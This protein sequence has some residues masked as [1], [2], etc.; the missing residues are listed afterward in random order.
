MELHRRCRST[1]KSRRCHPKKR[2]T[3]PA[4][5]EVT[6]ELGWTTNAD[7]EVVEDIPSWRNFTG[8]TFE[9]VKGSGWSKALHPDDLE[10]TLKTWKRATQ[11]KSKCEVEYRLRRNDGVYRYL[12]TRGVPVF[13]EDG[14]IR[15]WVGTCIDITVRKQ[16]EK[17]LEEYSKH[18][19][20]LVEERTKQL[21]DSERLA[22]IGATAGMVGH[23]IRNPLQAIIGDIF[24]AKADLS[25]LSENEQKISVQESLSEIEKNVEYINKIVAD[26]Q[27]FA[28]P[29]NPTAMEIDLKRIID[30]VANNRRIPENIQASIKVE[31]G[32]EK[33][34]VDSAYVQR[35]LSN[36]VNNAVQAMPNGGKLTVHAYREG[37]DN[38][39]TVADTGVG[40]PEEAKSKLF[41]PLF[42]TK[43]KG[44]GFG[45]AVVK[46]MTEALGGTVTFESQA[47]KGTKFIVRLPKRTN[48]KQ[49]A[50]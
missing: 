29:L 13:K 26:L 11:E 20:Q 37:K 45:L 47:E 19:E 6:G 16:M 14:N 15:E 30:E 33:I 42:T 50:K 1:Q 49:A 5:I 41:T 46:R 38:V 43:S 12:M 8:Q 34:V 21:R 17:K 10:K 25:S 40:I 48:G 28:K 3:L 2:T 27:D 4:F 44:Q 24:L 7:G 31:N 18:L 39:I 35:I 23:D 32:A 22:A 9:E 36:L